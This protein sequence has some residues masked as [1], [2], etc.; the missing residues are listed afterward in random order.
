MMPT[1]SEPISYRQH[2]LLLAL[3]TLLIM[4]VF[5]QIRHHDYVY[6]DEF[7]YISGNDYVLDGLTPSSIRWAF[8]T[9]LHS[10]W[11]PMTWLS[12][13]LDTELFGAAPASYHL[14]NLFWH[15]AASM[16]LYVLLWRMTGSWA[17]SILVAA[18]FAVH[19]LH[20]ESVAWGPERKD[21]LSTFFGL[22]CLIAYVQYASGGPRR[23]WYY[24]A[25]ILLLLFGLMSK[26]MLV[27]WPF[28]ML[29]L[30]YWP[31]N[32]LGKDENSRPIEPAVVGYRL[33]EKVP[34][35]V[36]VM[37]FSVIT[38]IT[39]SRGGSTST[40]DSLPLGVRISN[41]FVSYVWYL[42]K[43]VWPS[44]LGVFYPHYWSEADRRLVMSNALIC[45][46][47]LIAITAAI[48]YFGRR[49]P[50]LLFG[51]A[52]YLGTLV[53]VIGIVQVGFQ[54]RA[55]RY[56]Y[57][58]LI[59]IFIIVAWS[60]YAWKGASLRHVKFAHGA[61]VIAVLVCATLTYR[62]V[63]I[64]RNQMSLFEH[65][66]AVTRSNFVT[67]FQLGYG[68]KTI[69]EDALAIAHFQQALEMRP[70][71][72][73]AHYHLGLLMEEKSPPVALRH[74]IEA[75]RLGGDNPLVLHRMAMVFMG[76]ENLEEAQVAME[77]ALALLPDNAEFHETLGEIYLMQGES[78]KA[79]I[80]LRHALELQPN[81]DPVRENR[82]QLDTTQSP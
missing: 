69:G 1:M 3:L 31:Q 41:S 62:Q 36:S 57:V 75:Y 56:T 55:D 81:L 21:T 15:W 67:T 63:G 58:P 28:V 37:V 18:L 12:L 47:L 66:S 54:A 73:S 48:L 68:Y 50:Y 71:L 8:V 78:A 10:N 53:P 61:A 16:L 76:L 80:H 44:G 42:Q 24:G 11:H 13:M 2:G 51:W 9:N 33:L 72:A 79:Q 39:Q 17:P 34:F 70:G 59:G 64:W 35:F 43:T 27:T 77:H 29:L 7:R 19:P 60:L 26:S 23:W 52:W 25:S 40:F 38:F 32:R 6:Y 22:A 45:A 82:E 14:M 4:L 30:D 74:Y 46:V 5:A 20:V 65:T 49:R